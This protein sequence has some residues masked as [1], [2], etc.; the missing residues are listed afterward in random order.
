MLPLMASAENKTITISTGEWPPF[1][2]QNLK[3][4]GVV[5]RIITESF[6]SQNIDVEYGWF[7]WKRAYNNVKNGNWD[8]SAIWAITP[9]RSKELLFSDPVIENITVMFFTKESYRDWKTLD[10][11]SGL[12]IGATNGYFNGLEFEQAEK[13]G[14]LT[15]QRTSIE[16]SNFKKLAAQHI[17]AVIAEIDTG[18]DIMHQVLTA[19]QLESIIVNPKK[20]SSFNNH[21]VISKKIDNAE[22]LISKF[23]KGL[24]ELTESGKVEQYFMESRNKQYQKD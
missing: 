8:A 12:V 9:E 14:V 11:L 3:H 2:S 1:I 22:K 18:Y 10:D 15:V 19:E 21:L 6:A 4:N 20:V 7:P 16:S 24:K 17:D 13:S 5:T 23:N